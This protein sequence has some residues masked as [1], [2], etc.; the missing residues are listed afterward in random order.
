MTK[1]R[2]AKAEETTMI[3]DD[4]KTK[5]LTTKRNQASEPNQKAEGLGNAGSEGV[6]RRFTYMAKEVG[7]REIRDKKKNVSRRTSALS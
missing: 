4:A 6:D 7:R 2:F 3:R 5:L 1:A